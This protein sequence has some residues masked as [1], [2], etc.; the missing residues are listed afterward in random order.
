[1]SHSYICEARGDYPHLKQVINN[2]NIA[3][4]IIIAIGPEG[5]WTDQELEIAVKSGFIAISL[6]R[7]ILRA[8]T[9]P[10]VAISLI[11]AN[12]ELSP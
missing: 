10:I 5:G 11:A 12:F 4:E 6:G 2:T 8:V 1:A 3:K 9:A 7:R